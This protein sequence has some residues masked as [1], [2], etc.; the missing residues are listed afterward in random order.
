MMSLD[1]LET[2]VI[3]NCE[4]ADAVRYT[5]DRPQRKKENVVLHP[6]RNGVALFEYGIVA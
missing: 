5:A 4:N 1:V 6:K 2:A 3:R